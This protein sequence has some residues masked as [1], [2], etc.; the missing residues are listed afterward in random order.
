MNGE[1]SLTGT[2]NVHGIH[3]MVHCLKPRFSLEFPEILHMPSIVLAPPVILESSCI[4]LAL[5]P[6][7]G[8]R[9]SSLVDLRS[10]RE[11]LWRN[12]YLAARPAL[13][14]ES[15][16]EHLDGGGWD[17]ILPSVSPCRLADGRSIPDH[18][19][20]VRLPA[21][22]VSASGDR[23][24]LTADLRSLPLRFTRELRVEEA[25]LTIHYALE[26]LAVH[27][28]PWLWAAHP[29]FALEPGMEISRIHGVAF[30][31]AASM[32]NAAG[33]D[34]IIPDFHAADFV[35]FACKLFSGA[36]ALAGV[37]LRHPDGSGIELDWDAAEIPH[38]GLWLN[39]G[40]WSGCGSPPY[41]NLGIE[42]TTSPHDSL[43]D[44]VRAGEAM[45]LPAGETRT[46]SMRIEVHEH[47]TP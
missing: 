18:G 11:W 34:G 32:G 39:L 23:C 31:T 2:G 33:F 19:D 29:L 12:P 44:A 30:D 40:A 17:E 16:T 20:A 4:R 35:Q 3:P 7:L 10:G 24:V 8:G 45:I 47:H 21:K 43:A 42:P 37:G 22:V 1:L 5:R 36:G 46:W 41:F 38:L 14:V 6:E 13:G 26:S 25:R 27:D 9:I 28:V 15:Y